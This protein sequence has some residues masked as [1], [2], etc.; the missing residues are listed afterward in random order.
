[1][2]A[3]LSAAAIQY[4]AYADYA[5]L[6]GLIESSVRDGIKKA[7]HLGAAATCSGPGAARV[8]GVCGVGSALTLGGAAQVLPVCQF[9]VNACNGYPWLPFLC[10]LSF[11]VCQATQVAPTLAA[12][13]RVL[14]VRPPCRAGREASPMPAVGGSTAGQLAWLKWGP[15]WRHASGLAAEAVPAERHSFCSAPLCKLLPALTLHLCLQ[16]YDIRKECVGPLCYGAPVPA[17]AAGA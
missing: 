3:G 15:G 4:G 12:T 8:G 6:N 14:N 9:L 7:R 1:M 17:P 16:V 11:T 13:G 5:A 10:S 2:T